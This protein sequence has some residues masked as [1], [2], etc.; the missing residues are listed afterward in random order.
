LP[1]ARRSAQ[2]A[3]ALAAALLLLGC[4]STPAPTTELALS[5]AA[6]ST[7]E[8][9][10]A[11]ELAPVEMR[12]ARDKLVRAR[13]AVAAEDNT[14]ARRLA[15]QSLAEAQLAAAKAQSTKARNAA[16]ELQASIRVLREEINRQARP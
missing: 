7:A 2:A 9:A 14:L 15:E 16:A 10:G 5:A 6:I 4:A 8:N 13:A 3:A 12:S 11:P 1:A